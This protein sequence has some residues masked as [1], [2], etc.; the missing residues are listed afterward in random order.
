MK[1]IIII[2][3][4]FLHILNPTKK[5]TKESPFPRS[6]KK[7]HVEKKPLATVSNTNTLLRLV[8]DAFNS[9]PCLNLEKM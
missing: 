1:G 7:W 3:I 4:L 6:P 5:K 8:A 2:I 9:I